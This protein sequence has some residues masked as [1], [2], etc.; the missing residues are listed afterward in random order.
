MAEFKNITV[1]EKRSFKDMELREITLFGVLVVLVIVFS[2]LAPNFF[3][4]NN[5]M[6]LGI[7]SASLAITAAG[8]TFV[9][10]TGEDGT[11]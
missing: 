8:M 2:F 11:L 1:T 3:K 5:F 9:I 6:N 10:I 4:V 7:Y